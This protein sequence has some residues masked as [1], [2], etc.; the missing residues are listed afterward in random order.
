[1]WVVVHVLSGTAQ[2]YVN[3]DK[4]LESLRPPK[5]ESHQRR[6]RSS[7]HRKVSLAIRRSEHI[8]FLVCQNATTAAEVRHVLIGTCV[9]VLSRPSALPR[10]LLASLLLNPSWNLPANMVP[11][12]NFQ[13]LLLTPCP[14]SNLRSP[15]FRQRL[16]PRPRKVT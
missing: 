11:S 10:S 5:K 1:M 14:P 16:L 12:L 4:F 9:K 8:T 15:P 7:E 3:N 6:T 13:R 2:Q